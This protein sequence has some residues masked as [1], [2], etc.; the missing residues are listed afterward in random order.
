MTLKLRTNSGAIPGAPYETSKL[1][2]ESYIE[3]LTDNLH[4][5]FV[6]THDHAIS[7][8][9]F[10]GH[11][12]SDHA[13]SCKHVPVW[14]SACINIY[15]YIYKYIYIYICI[16]TRTVKILQAMSLL[17]HIV[18]LSLSGFSS[19]NSKSLT[20]MLSTCVVSHSEFTAPYMVYLTVYLCPS[21]SF[22]V[23]INTS[24]DSSLDLSPCIILRNNSYQTWSETENIHVFGALMDWVFS[25]YIYMKAK[26]MRVYHESWM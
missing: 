15:I 25:I 6:D 14:F 1:A 10:C 3:N 16:R 8:D 24:S 23:C 19:H 12:G 22:W 20:L 18:V 21:I 4:L 17:L 5:S 7:C 2:S 26:Y 13:V 9:K 11:I